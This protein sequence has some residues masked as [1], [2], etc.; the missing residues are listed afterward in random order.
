MGMTLFL[1]SLYDLMMVAPR[2]WHEVAENIYLSKLSTVSGINLKVIKCQKT[3]S[4]VQCW[5][6]EL[7]SILT[8]FSPLPSAKLEVL[9]L[10]LCWYCSNV[11]HG[12]SMNL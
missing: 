4:V 3:S 6:E 2:S 11:G 7:G 10:V 9:M 8:S 1:T 12:N 5:P